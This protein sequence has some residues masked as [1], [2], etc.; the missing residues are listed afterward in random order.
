M[1][2]RKLKSIAA[3]ASARYTERGSR[4]F[5]YAFPVRDPAEIEKRRLDTREKHPDA[6]HHCY[7]LRYNPFQ[8]QEFVQDDGEPTGTAGQPILGVIK[9]E[10]LVNVLII[11]VRYYGGTKLGKPGLIKAYR[12]AASQALSTVDKRTLDRFTPF[13]IEYPYEQESRIRELL[14]RFRLNI[15]QEQYYEYVTIT[16]NCKTDLAS[17][18]RGVLDHMKHIDIHYS[19]RPECFL[20]TEKNNSHGGI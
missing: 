1:S 5:A 2:H 11:V 15:D 18:L 19:T 16:V 8:T 17:Q 3:P 7:A 13:V 10:E 12:Q 6:T 14:N 4:F 9:S 20:M